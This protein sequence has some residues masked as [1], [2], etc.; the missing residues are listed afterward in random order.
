MRKALIVK[1][2]ITER[3]R[4]HIYFVITV[5]L[6]LNAFSPGFSS[7]SFVLGYYM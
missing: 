2:N 1:V 7:N 4:C 6:T 5:I 3:S